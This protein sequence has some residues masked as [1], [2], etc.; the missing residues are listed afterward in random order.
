MNAFTP[1]R[2][3]TQVLGTLAPRFTAG[4]ARHLMM[5]PQVHAPREWELAALQGAERITFRFG[6]SGLRWGTSGPV[7]LLMHGWQGRPTQFRHLI[8]PLVANGRQVI[9]LE[10]PGHG[11][12]PGPDSNV[13][14]FAQ[15]LLEAAAELRDV[16]S[17]VGHS[18]GGSAALIALSERRFAERA[19]V[20]GSPASLERMIARFADR[21]ALPSVAR[22]SL[23][24]L[25]D[26]HVGV[27]AASLDSARLAPRLM[28]PGL[29]VHDH[30][31][32]S[33]PFKEG[34]TI[35][36]QWT[37][38]RFLATH[39]LGHRQVLADPSVVE[40]ITAFLVGG[41]AVH[42]AHAA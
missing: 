32:E 13:Y 39:R 26:R 1:I 41:E 20:I 8:A 10:A 27:S 7:V 2:A 11:Q 30:D 42:L 34:E 38:A 21:I 4:L 14:L 31:D 15:A 17:V 9:A 18:M 5:T 37:G 33:V 23:S 29:V 36:R 3:S 28:L 16:E 22:R 12:S 25:V 6:L 19:V 24:E 35:A 40:A